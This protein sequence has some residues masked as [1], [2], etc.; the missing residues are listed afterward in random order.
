MNDRIF[1]GCYPTGFVFA[2]RK[3][4]K[5]GDYKRLAYINYGTLKLEME[6]DV[7]NHLANDIRAI[8]ED[9]LARVGEPYQIAGNCII[10]LGYA[11]WL[12]PGT[13]VIYKGEEVENL[14]RWFD[15]LYEI[16]LNDGSIKKVSMHNLKKPDTVVI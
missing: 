3:V 16:K 7:P 14:G 9:M 13:T 11:L 5:N 2:D 8:H 10:E 4:E 15:Q 6:D 12:E 1:C